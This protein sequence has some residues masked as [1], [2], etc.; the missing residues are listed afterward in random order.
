MKVASSGKNIGLGSNVGLS[1]VEVIIALAIASLFL[2][3]AFNLISTIQRM[4]LDTGLSLEARVLAKNNLDKV[5]RELRE[6]FTATSST[7]F[8]ISEPFSSS[9]TIF[10]I[11][12]CRREVKSTV[13]WSTDMTAITH[14]TTLDRLVGSLETLQKIGNDCGGNDFVTTI[15]SSTTLAITSL[16]TPF[17]VK[18]TGVDILNHTAFVLAI[19]SDPQAPDMLVAEVSGENFQ[20]TSSLDFGT[21]GTGSNAL[22]AVS[23]YVFV[24]QHSTTSQLVVVDVR[25]PNQPFVAA[26]STL[27]GV[28]G[29]KPQGW[30]IYYYDSKVYIGTKRTAGHEFH[31]F[32]VVNP[33]NPVWLGSR[34][35]NHNINSI[36]VRGGFAYLATSGNVKDLIVLDVRNPAIITGKT[37]LDL[38]G[39][40]DGK[41]LYLLANTLYLGR[42]KSLTNSGHK[43]FYALDISQI[44]QAP[45]AD[46]IRILGS[47]DIHADVN[48]I[49]VVGSYA[50]LSTSESNREL[51]I[52]KTTPITSTSTS[53]TAV[54]SVNLPGKAT[55]IDYE[56]A[57]LIIPVFDTSEIYRLK[58]TP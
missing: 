53:I 25:N 29:A 33:A 28:A 31:I 38:P 46:T 2:T 18:P 32:D 11:T 13:G 40:E 43:D 45:P 34:E 20:I 12:P 36:V 35:V 19:S 39:N 57:T 51:T 7:P 48:S 42:F 55:G 21:S 17:D 10:D 49:R 56:N 54:T 3:E 15:T 44:P 1:L 52:L 58:L 14:N 24:A 30:S 8:E 50:F 5:D 47:Y 22:D 41:S 37:N 4:A 6:N 9:V 26:S 27:P 16:A 23:S